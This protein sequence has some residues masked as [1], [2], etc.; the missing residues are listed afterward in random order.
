MLASAAAFRSLKRSAEFGLEA[1]HIGFDF[2]KVID[3]KDWVVSQIS[4]PGLRRFFESQGV[5]VLEGTARFAALNEADINGQK[6]TFEKAVIATGSTPFVPPIEGLDTIDYMTSN[7]AINLRELPSSIIIIGGSSVGLEFAT[8]YSSFGSEVTIVEALPRIAFKEDTEVSLALSKYLSEQG[9]A[10]YTNVKI[11]KVFVEGSAKSLVIDTADGEAKLSAS[12]LLVATGR[13]ALTAGL[14]LEDIGIEV[15]K[16]GIGVNEYLQT[17]VAHIYAA[18]DVVPFIQLAQAAAYEGDLV[19]YNAFAGEKKALDLRVMP[20]ATWSYPEVA[21]VGITED[22][23][24]DNKL[25]YLVQK[26][27]FAGLGRALADGERKGFVKIIADANSEEVLGCHIIG[28]HA[29]EM[30]HQATQAMQTRARI[31]ALAKTIHCELTMSEGM[32]NAYIDLD[33]ALSERRAKRK[34]A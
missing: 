10:I 27:P 14:G 16:G 25:S 21:S 15:V 24:K 22:E 8:I 9:I 34:T 19:G 23:A 29:D 32:G 26:F 1:E 28:S 13:H 3:R 31:G 5:Q 7:D 11:K 17:S 12:K 6:I 30:I 33:D 20:R 18:G 2:S 4:G